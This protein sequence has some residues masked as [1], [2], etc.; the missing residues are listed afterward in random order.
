MLE[1]TKDSI[2]KTLGVM[3][4]LTSVGMLALVG[5]GVADAIFNGM[6]GEVPLAALT[7]A[8]PILIGSSAIGVGLS[9]GA[10]AVL[11]PV[12]GQ[13]DALRNAEG[14]NSA[15]KF[16]N[17]ALD[18]SIGCDGLDGGAL[19]ALDGCLNRG[20]AGYAL[21]QSLASRYAAFLIVALVQGGLARTI[22]DP[23][24]PAIV[25]VIAAL[26]N[27]GLDPILIFGIDGWVPAY[28]FEGAAYATL[29]TKVLAGA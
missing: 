17:R 23:Q 29:A 7:Y 24:T 12:V 8:F 18:Y 11:A 22:G 26:L 10:E 4:L 9:V 14:G 27:I 21:H 16:R 25:M 15:P 6:L 2:P 20:T 19:P 5:F 3:A 1:L 28:G 13:G